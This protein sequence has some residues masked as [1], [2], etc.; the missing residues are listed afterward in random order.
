MYSL[1]S[2]TQQ[3]TQISAST[4]LTT[5]SPPSRASSQ[6]LSVRRSG[7]RSTSGIANPLSRCRAICPLPRAEH[8]RSQPRRTGRLRCVLAQ[9]ESHRIICASAGEPHRAR[10][11]GSRRRLPERI[12]ERARTCELEQFLD[13]CIWCRSHYW[14][15]GVPADGGSRSSRRSDCE[16][17]RSG[18]M[19]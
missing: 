9:H 15:C 16:C 7:L 13:E 10:P 11:A 5:R 19:R 18:F 4:K 14:G 17:V 12:D 3:A 1:S 6:V 2:Q 8:Q